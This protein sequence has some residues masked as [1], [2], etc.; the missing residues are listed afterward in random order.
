MVTTKVNYQCQEEYLNE[1]ACLFLTKGNNCYYDK[2][3]S[4]NTYRCK[5]FTDV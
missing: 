5:P 1:Y 2:T 4:P 3:G